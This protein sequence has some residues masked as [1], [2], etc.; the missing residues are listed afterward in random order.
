MCSDKSLTD[1]Y[2]NKIDHLRKEILCL[3]LE[4][5]GF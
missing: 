1:E 4:T 3:S 2:N 5:I